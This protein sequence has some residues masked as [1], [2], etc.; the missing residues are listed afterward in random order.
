MGFRQAKDH[1]ALQSSLYFGARVQKW[2]MNLRFELDRQIV[3]LLP[4]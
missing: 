3:D 2:Q 1:E 4:W